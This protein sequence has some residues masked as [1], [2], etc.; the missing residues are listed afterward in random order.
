VKCGDHAVP[1][2]TREEFG[3]F[4]VEMGIDAGYVMDSKR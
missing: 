4:G 2:S 1:K 3:P